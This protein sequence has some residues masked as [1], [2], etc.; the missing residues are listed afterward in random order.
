[1]AE[2]GSRVPAGDWSAADNARRILRENK[3]PIA[4]PSRVTK[5]LREELK[6]KGLKGFAKGGK[7]KKT[8][9][10]KVHKGEYVIKKTAAQKLGPKKLAAMNRGK[11]P[12]RAAPKKAVPRWPMRMGK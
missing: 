9:K 5:E 2:S 10:A 8:G 4:S 7:V 12:A 11:A 6:T 1:M 3:E